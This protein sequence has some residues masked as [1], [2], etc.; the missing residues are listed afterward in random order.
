MA[1]QRKLLFLL[2][3]SPY[4]SSLARSAVD[5]CLAAAAFEQEVSVLF[6]GEGV[7]QLLPGQDGDAI[8]TRTLSKIIASFELYDINQIYADA[9][10]LSA[11]GL[12]AGLL[13]PGIEVVS[14]QGIRSC[15]AEADHVLGF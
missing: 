4:A 2:R 11:H 7:L 9:R 15:L 5:S 13:P 12:N 10:A 6:M 8:G 1:A 3:H 14:D